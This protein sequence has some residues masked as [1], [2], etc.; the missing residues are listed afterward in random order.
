MRWR[1]RIRQSLGLLLRP[2][3]LMN[4]ASEPPPLLPLPLRAE[5]SGA[6]EPLLPLLHP[7]PPLMM[8]AGASLVAPA[9]PRR[10][11]LLLLPRLQTLSQQLPR[12]TPSQSRARSEH[13][14]PLL[15][16][17][18][19]RRTPSHQCPESLHPPLLR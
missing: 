10:L 1:Q 4:G 9:S 12:R 6:S 17:Q 18:L 15:L 2:P 7:R 8:G 5:M 14:H 11:P 3:Q 16:L 19:P 13:H